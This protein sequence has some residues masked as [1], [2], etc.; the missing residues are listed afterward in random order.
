MSPVAGNDVVSL[1]QR[2]FGVDAS[3]RSGLLSS[4]IYGQMFDIVN[5]CFDSLHFDINT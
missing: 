1:N 4:A 3:T 2:T 5:I